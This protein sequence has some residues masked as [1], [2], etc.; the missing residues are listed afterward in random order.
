MFK[1]DEST[2]PDGV[3][4]SDRVS[5]VGGA[6]GFDAQWT[7][8]GCQNGRSPCGDRRDSVGDRSV[9]NA[10][11]S[12]PA[13]GR[14]ARTRLRTSRS[15]AARL[16]VVLCQRPNALPTVV[17]ATVGE[18]CATSGRNFAVLESQPV[19]ARGMSGGPLE[20]RTRR[21]GESSEANSPML[22]W[23]WRPDS[24]RS[25]DSPFAHGP[26]R[27]VRLVGIEHMPRCWTD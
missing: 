4:D 25:W 15:R 9:L 10:G 11:R 8:S 16:T 21:S 22:V 14:H 19:L 13:A 12:G 17:F 1:T 27:Q 7:A 26:T 23:S 3:P 24:S 2:L 6:I 18:R 20:C 5:F